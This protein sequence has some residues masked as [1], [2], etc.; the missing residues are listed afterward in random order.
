MNKLFDLLRRE[1]KPDA[2][3]L[4]AYL[5]GAL[6]D[7]RRAETE[8][9]VASCE[10]CRARVAELRALRADLA[11][12]PHADAPRP[13]RLRQADLVDVREPGGGWAAAPLMRAASVTAAMAVLLFGVVFAVQRSGDDDAASNGLALSR[14]SDDQRE[15]LE[16]MPDA[17][18]GA[19]E[20]AGGVQPPAEATAAAAEAFDSAGIGTAAARAGSDDGTASAGQVTPGSSTPGSAAPPAGSLADVP[21]ASATV[22]AEAITGDRV[23]ADDDDGNQYALRVVLLVTA[24]VIAV[25]ALA[26]IAVRRGRTT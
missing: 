15:A 20:S 3:N 24:G 25:V 18:T 26:A 2:V 14:A 6:D 7:A 10:V 23:A 16:P 22:S 8:S 4:S 21:A 19:S 1:H 11:A 5:D 12:M 13:F 17:A 9:H